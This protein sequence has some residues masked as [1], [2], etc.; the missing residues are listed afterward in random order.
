MR[1]D[2]F[3]DA[4]I[5]ANFR[6]RSKAQLYKF[7]ECFQFPEWMRSSKSRNVFHREEVVLLGLFRMSYPNKEDSLAYKQIFGFK[8][9]QVSKCFQVFIKTVDLPNGMNF[10]AWGPVSVRH[11]DLYTYSRSQDLKS[12]RK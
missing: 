10:H 9:H 1:V 8:Y 4:D 6:F 11:N 2:Q 5:E 3:A 12:T 7:I